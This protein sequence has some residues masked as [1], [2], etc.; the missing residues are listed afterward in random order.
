M[1]PARYPTALG[2]NPARACEI[3]TQSTCGTIIRLRDGCSASTWTAPDGS[4]LL[5][6][7]ASSVQT[8]PDGYRRIVWMIKW[9]IK[10]HPT[11][12]RCAYR[13]RHAASRRLDRSRRGVL[14]NGRVGRWWA[15]RAGRMLGRWFAIRDG[16]AAGWSCEPGWSRPTPPARPESPPPA[17]GLA[18]DRD[19]HQPGN[20]TPGGDAGQP[21]RSP[22]TVVADGAG[23]IESV[24]RAG[25]RYAS[26]ACRQPDC[27]GWKALSVG[28]HY[29]G[30]IP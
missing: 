7:D 5:T 3:P 6:L 26:C 13:R 16:P 23:V 17:S 29:P 30:V 15:G 11:Q 12:N 27:T 21:P 10:A 9:M 28:A 18:A 14:P 4:G 22:L 20:R 1:W 19:C 8:A 24:C 2:L 25:H